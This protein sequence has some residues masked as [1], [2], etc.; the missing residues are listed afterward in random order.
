MAAGG[1]RAKKLALC[2]HPSGLPGPHSMGWV[3]LAG[4]IMFLWQLAL[5]VHFS[6]PSFPGPV[7]RVPI[8]DVKR[9]TGSELRLKTR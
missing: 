9:W 4:E 5:P 2:K 6:R 7:G 8:S 1:N 3:D